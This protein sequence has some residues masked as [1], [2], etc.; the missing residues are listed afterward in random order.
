MSS[1]LESRPFLQPQNVNTINRNA[2]YIARMLSFLIY[3]QHT[4]VVKFPV[5][6]HPHLQTSFE[7]L[8]I[9]LKDPDA[10]DQSIQ[11]CIHDAVW[12][13]LTKTSAEFH[14][15]HTMC[16]FTRF[17]LASHL[18]EGGAVATAKHITPSISY[19]QW[20]FRATGVAQILK[21]MHQYNNNP[22]A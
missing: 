1:S 21:I 14:R 22:M 4:P 15:D 2:E 18:K 20:G 12:Q 10:T 3:T 7:N 13:L 5:F 17:L 9:K 11:D 6:L 16:L 19:A 8:L